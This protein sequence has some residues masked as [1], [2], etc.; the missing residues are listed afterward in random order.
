MK[1][2]AAELSIEF[3]ARIFFSTDITLDVKQCF[4]TYFKRHLMRHS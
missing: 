4:Q 1:I 3:V 2:S